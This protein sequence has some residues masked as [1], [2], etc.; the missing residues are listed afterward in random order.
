[1]MKIGPIEVHAP[2]TGMFKLDG[3]AMFGTVPKPLW[4][5]AIPPDDQ[6]RIPMSL[7]VM[8][9]KDSSTGRNLIV[10]TGIGN[11]WSEKLQKIY[12]IDHSQFS[13]EKALQSCGLKFD[14]ITDV[15]LTHLHFDH[16]G[17]STLLDPSGALVP[18]FPH[19]RYYIQKDNFDWATRPSSREAAS[20]LPENFMPLQQAGKLVIC[21]GPED[22]EKKINWPG[23]SVRVSYG[24]TI[25][26]QC[27]LYKVG[28]ETFFYPSDLIPTS[29]HI[30]LP[31]V[32]G[33]D[34]H[35]I[36]ILEEKEKILEESAAGNWTLV[37]EHD[38]VH[39]ATKVVKGPKH[40]ERG[41]VVSL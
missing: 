12:A 11:K 8:I 24:H 40:F 23:L 32:M 39:P 5:K 41:A 25:G 4:E 22:F 20:Y 14:Q 1:M 9:L 19:A 29:S 27:P 34:I 10:D 30:P 13:L 31:W 18:T 7:R 3:G 35:V 17:G 37:F 28:Q 38:P 21:D 36:Q 16:T 33:Y 26:L 15:L 6:N 2:N